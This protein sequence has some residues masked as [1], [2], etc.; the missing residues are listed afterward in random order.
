MKKM[1]KIIDDFKIFSIKLN[2]NRKNVNTKIY[3][4]NELIWVS[5]EQ[6]KPG[7]IHQYD[8]DDGWKINKVISTKPL[9]NWFQEI[10]GSY[11]TCDDGTTERYTGDLQIQPRK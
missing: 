1:K 11:I 10:I 5:S 3:K 7:D 9:K 8:D 4:E 6:I 2:E